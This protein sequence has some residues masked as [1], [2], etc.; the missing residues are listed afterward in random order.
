MRLKVHRK[1][2]GNCNPSSPIT[3]MYLKHRVIFISN[4]SSL[5][6]EQIV[7]KTRLWQ[8][9]IR[10]SE[11][12]GKTARASGKS[13]FFFLLS[14]SFDFHPGINSEDWRSRE[15]LC[16]IHL[17]LAIFNSQN[18][19]LPKDTVWHEDWLLMPL[20]RIGKFSHCKTTFFH[21]STL[22]II[23][24]LKKKALTISGRPLHRFMVDKSQEQPVHSMQAMTKK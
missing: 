6:T 23:R 12:E 15:L 18:S 7:Q 2:T 24:P 20:G 16:I 8:W 14:H 19:T 3:I 22:E 9:S 21:H 13:F 10:V 4:F 11:L 17:F 1:V 5:T